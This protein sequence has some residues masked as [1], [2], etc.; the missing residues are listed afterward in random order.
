MHWG[1]A[2]SKDLVHWEELPE[3]LFPDEHGTMF[4]GSAV[5]DYDNTSG[6]VKK[7]APAMVAIYT[8]DNPE[9]G[10]VKIPV[11]RKCSGINHPING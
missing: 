7:G 4:S 9:N 11:I 10:T 8:A 5:I 3:A 2:V 1:H 6:F